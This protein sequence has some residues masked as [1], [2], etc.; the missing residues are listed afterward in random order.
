MTDSKPYF[1]WL[2]SSFMFV[3]ISVSIFNYIIDPY[4]IFRTFY[5]QGINTSKPATSNRTALAKAYM[6]NDINAKTLIVGTSSFDIG[7]DPESSL[8]PE[9]LQPVFN[10][11]IP[12]ANIYKQY[13][14]IQHAV[15]LYKPEMIIL[16]IEFQSFLYENEGYFNDLANN[17][18]RIYENRLNVTYSGETNND[19]QFQYFKDLVASLLSITATIDSGRTII[20]GDNEW[21]NKTGLSSG[22][23]RFGNEVKNKGHFSVFRDV[24]ISH[25][26][27]VTGKVTSTESPGIK[28]L[29]EIVKFCKKENIRLILVIPP[30]H[31][32]VYQLW[33]S[34]GLW[35]EFEYWKQVILQTI[36][37]TDSNNGGIT[38]LD[39][40]TYNKYTIEQVPEKSD[41][42]YKMNWF[43]EPIHFKTTLGNRILEKIFI[44]TNE[45]TLFGAE[46]TQLRICEH[47]KR[48]RTSKHTYILNNRD[49]IELLNDMVPNISVITSQSD[50]TVSNRSI[51]RY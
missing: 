48:N 7:I 36:K 39:F 41:N 10:L 9:Y 19:K 12:G 28:T 17:L 14:Y 21:I 2:F 6:V 42:K 24:L 38:I 20:E 25:I 3:I 26:P 40:A 37:S 50:P 30:Y 4:N 46:L 27:T 29:K 18:D 8:F 35:E 1:K 23:A 32:F 31:V 16:S 11:A 34:L 44:K 43:W 22:F 15:S 13:R 49:Q 47:L 33:D 45:R 51:C 5:I